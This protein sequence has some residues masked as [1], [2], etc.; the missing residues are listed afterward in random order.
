MTGYITHTLPHNQ[1]LGFEDDDDVLIVEL[2]TSNYQVSTRGRASHGLY[3]TVKEP[4]NSHDLSD[5]ETIFATEKS[6]HL[7]LN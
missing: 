7:L 1:G 4:G 6:V 2:L 5:P 3:R